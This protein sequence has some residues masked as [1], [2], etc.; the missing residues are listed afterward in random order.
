MPVANDPK[1]AHPEDGAVSVAESEDNENK[2]DT[3]DEVIPEKISTRS[4][5][6]ESPII[7]VRRRPSRSRERKVTPIEPTRRKSYTHRSRKPSTPITKDNDVTDNQIIVERTKPKFPYVETQ[8][9]GSKRRHQSSRFKERKATP[10]EPTKRMSDTHH[11]S[12]KPSTTNE[13]KAD[14]DVFEEVK[15]DFS[16]PITQHDSSRRRSN[17]DRELASEGTT[18][19]MSKS[20]NLRRIKAQATLVDTTLWNSRRTVN[21]S[22]SLSDHTEESHTILNTTVTDTD[23]MT[24]LL[25]IS[26]KES[27]NG[28]MASDSDDSDGPPGDLDA[29]DHLKSVV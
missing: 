10:R 17:K 9:D 16:R 28:T 3:N 27:S 2:D 26:N 18:E 13:D 1:V 11:R 14:S 29:S 5:H 4:P 24:N 19:R 23:D 8:Y 6:L 22:I 15:V 25:N 21:H 7:G 12:R 20:H